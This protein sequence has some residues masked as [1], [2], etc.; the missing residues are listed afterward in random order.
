MEK[1]KWDLKVK[2]VDEAESILSR[3]I[4]LYKLYNNEKKKESSIR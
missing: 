4:V 3:G 1:S 2:V